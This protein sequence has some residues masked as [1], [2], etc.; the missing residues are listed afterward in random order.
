MK[1][2]WV[3]L[4]IFLTAEINIVYADA[5]EDDSEKINIETALVSR[6]LWRGYNLGGP[7]FQ[8]SVDFEL[9]GNNSH[10]LKIG[11]WGYSDFNVW[12]KEVDLSLSYYFFNKKA[13]I[14]LYD[15]WYVSEMTQDYFNY[16]NN[17]TSHAFEIQLNYTFNPTENDNIVFSWATFIYGDDKKLSSTN[18]YKQ[19]YSGYF[20]IKYIKDCLFSK[21]GFETSIGFSPWESQTSY[22]VDKFS[23]VNA[24]L[25]FNREFRLNNNVEFT[26]TVAF[27]VNPKHNDAYLSFGVA[28]SF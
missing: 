19:A 18:S 17:S 12:T 11:A 6:Y 7:G 22:M 23:W 24:E 9:F 4:I 25:K 13:A 2:L 20:E 14:I 1:K 15:Y 10:A 26:P 3:I 16:K 21:Y 5:N 8:A 27:T 28:C